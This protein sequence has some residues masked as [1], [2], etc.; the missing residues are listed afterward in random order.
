V[1]LGSAHIWAHTPL[2]G[3]FA[4]A[5]SEEKNAIVAPMARTA[6]PPR[7][8]PTMAPIDGLLFLPSGVVWPCT[9]SGLSV[10]RIQPGKEQKLR[11]ASY[12]VERRAGPAPNQ[13]AR[14]FRSVLYRIRHN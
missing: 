5:L 10:D 14:C 11:I 7:T 3:R 13:S 8:P 12:L 9:K 2:V 4:I 1:D 6:T